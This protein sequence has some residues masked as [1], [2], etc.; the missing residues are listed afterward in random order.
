MSLTLKNNPRRQLKF[1]LSFFL[2]CLLCPL[3]NYAQTEFSTWGNIT[4]IRVD[5]QLM[6]F[7]T[8]LVVI[9]KENKERKTR[10]EGQKN[11]FQRQDSKKIFSYEMGKLDW[12]NSIQSFENGR[13]EISIEFSSEVDTLINGAYFRI[14]LPEIY[15]AATKFK[16]TTPEEL[17]FKDIAAK[18]KDIAY[19]AP[20]TAIRIETPTRQ[21]D[22]T[23]E[24]PTEIFI[25]ALDSLNPQFEINFLMAAENIPA[26]KTFSNKFSIKASGEIDK[27]PANLKIFP[28]QEGNPFDGIGGNFRLQ[29]PN[30]DPQ[31][32]DYS[33]K[34]LRVAW[35]R[36]EMPWRQWHPD[37]EKDPALEAKKGNLDPKVKAAMEMAQRLDKMGI[38]VILAGW[39][40]PD[41]AIIGERARG[42]NLDGSRGNPLDLSKKKE[43][44]SSIT[45]YIKY[46]EENYGVKVAMFSFN[47]ADLGIDIRQT[48]E[49]HNEF[50]KELGA[51]FKSQGLDTKF[52]LGDTADANGWPFATPGSRDPESKAYIGGVSFHSWRAWTDEN[53]LEWA[54]I[55]NRVKA[56]LFIGEGSIDAQAWGYPQIFEEPTY[57]LDEIEVYIKILNVAQPLT[58]LQWQLT[59][60]YSVLSGG[61][62]FG[63]TKEKLHPTQRFFNLKQLGETEKG[64]FAIPITSNKEG[65]TCAAFGDSKKGSYAIHIVNKGA[66]RKVE[67]S[68]LP[69]N[70]NTM[71]VFLTNQENSYKKIKTLNVTNGQLS[72]QLEGASYVSLTTK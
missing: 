9:D 43:I 44:Y 57:A 58:I 21:L 11:D 61:G 63:N 37:L 70:I 71:E 49:E 2:L 46:L 16:I 38:P 47:E 40:G 19:K 27:S 45:S 22:I 59:S 25:K 12:K 51:Y 54:A 18:V 1:G 7:N 6:E 55:T 35:S 36:V 20:A 41:W 26:G 5:N 56:P 10:R 33:L 4:G 67:L 72:F 14:S 65:L 62:V 50:I 8:N 42:V 3:T 17:S 60:D 68:G 31:V 48:P 32:I 52:L 29:N 28:E 39:F 34:N 64:L 15:N 13:S 24:H 30:A 53:L 69:K 23:F 66:T